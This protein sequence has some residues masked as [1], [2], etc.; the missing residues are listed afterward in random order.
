MRHTVENFLNSSSGTCEIP[1]PAPCCSMRNCITHSAMVAIK[2]TSMVPSFSD[3]STGQAEHGDKTEKVGTHSR[4][5]T[6]AG[7][8]AIFQRTWPR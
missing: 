2:A 7:A 4:P 3:V 8:S 1:T 6:G 5:T